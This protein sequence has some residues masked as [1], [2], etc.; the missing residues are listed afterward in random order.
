MFDTTKI[1]IKAGLAVDTVFV[2]SLLERLEKGRMSISGI[3]REGR[4]NFLSTAVWQS[5]G[6]SNQQYCVIPHLE[7]LQI[8]RMFDTTK[9]LLKPV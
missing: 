7:R 9:F 3:P 6:Y 1:S 2:I 5:L 8:G 4:Q